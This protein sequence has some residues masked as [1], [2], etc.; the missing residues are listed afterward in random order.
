MSYVAALPVTLDKVECWIEIGS[1]IEIPL[2]VGLDVEIVRQVL[3]GMGEEAAL[4]HRHD[5]PNV[6]P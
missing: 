3:F 1:Q 6:K 4:G 5:R 2:V